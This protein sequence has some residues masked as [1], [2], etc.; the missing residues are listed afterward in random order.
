VWGSWLVVTV[1]VFS[2]ISGITHPYYTVTPT[3]PWAL[4]PAIAGIGAV[5]L[6]RIRHT[7]AAHV[8]LARTLA[9]TLLVAAAWAVEPPFPDVRGYAPRPRSAP[10]CPGLS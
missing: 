3:T 6:W 7:W 1:E 9:R 4:A 10:G 5:A 2:Y 8:T